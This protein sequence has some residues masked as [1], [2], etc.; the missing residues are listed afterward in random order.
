MLQFQIDSPSEQVARYLRDELLLGTW[1]GKMPGAPLLAAELE[2]DRKT[3][4]AGLCLLER[5]GLLLAQGA[6]RRRKIVLPDKMAGPSLRVAILL[7]E[8][9]DRGMNYVLEV[10][11]ALAT[12]GHV[13]TFPPKGMVELGMDV[14]RIARLARAHGADAWVVLGASR[15]VLEW[16]VARGTPAMAVFGRRR[17]VPI[18]SVGPNKPPAMVATTR[19]LIGLGHQRIVLLARRMRRLPVPGASERAFL[20]EMA[21]HGIA[22]GAYHLPDWEESVDGFYARL[23]SLFRVTP[24]TALIIDE[25]SL[26]LAVQQFL[27]ARMLRVPEDVSLVCTDSSPNFDWCRP[28][29]AHIRWDSRPVVQRI[30]RWVANV[31][32]RKKD[33]RQT[34]TAAEFV[35]GG[36]IGP[37]QSAHP[38]PYRAG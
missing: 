19:E 12:A 37:V 9:A 25:V 28:T 26:F 13:V 7:G 33:L 32:R 16:F 34:L 23:D 8:G 30:A 6:G 18:A 29:V 36:T 21:A 15:A 31:S 35:R 1:R 27:A 10:E 22:P 4:E 17:G 11:H 5:E 24:P 38:G 2:V 3:V 20:D 14:R